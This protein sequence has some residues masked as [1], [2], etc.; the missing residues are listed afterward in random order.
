MAK[1]DKYYTLTK[2]SD[3]YMDN[4]V[5]VKKYRGKKFISKHLIISK[6]LEDWKL[7]LDQEGYHEKI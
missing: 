5:I 4:F 1:I 6:D 7:M 2:H 3:P